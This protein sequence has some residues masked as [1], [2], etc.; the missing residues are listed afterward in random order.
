MFSK[1]GKTKKCKA[2]PWKPNIIK[3]IILLGS[4]ETK[5]SNPKFIKLNE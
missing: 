4:V 3:I 2:I 5:R 1:S